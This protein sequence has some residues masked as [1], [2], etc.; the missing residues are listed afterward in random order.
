VVGEVVSSLEDDGTVIDWIT[1]ESGDADEHGTAP[2]QTENFPTVLARGGCNLAAVTH[3]FSLFAPKVVSEWNFLR[4]G[5]SIRSDHSTVIRYAVEGLPDGALPILEQIGYTREDFESS[6]FGA[7]MPAGAARILS[8]GADSEAPLYRHKETGLVIPFWMIGSL[9]YDLTTW[10]SDS[11]EASIKH[12][13]ARAALA[14]LRTHFEYLGLQDEARL[15]SN[16]AVIFD[17]VPAG[18]EVYLLL[19]SER[20]ALP[21]IHAKN[22]QLK[23]WLRAAAS[24]YECVKLVD[25]GSFIRD[26][27]EI[28]DANHFERM[29][30]FRIYEHIRSSVA[31][32]AAARM[33]PAIA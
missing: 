2:E 25:V 16:L 24:H 12:P 18:D 13:E 22:A 9:A 30:Y 1:L 8:V 15:K 14:Y 10:T 17:S 29:V 31:A 11:F 28:H 32:S 7:H 27:K 33:V 26:P 21:G 5:I 20:G 4:N 6:V 3:Y 19:P 23:N